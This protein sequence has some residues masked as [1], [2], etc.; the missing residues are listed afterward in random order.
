MV[1]I[2]IL[3]RKMNILIEEFERKI[4]N[5][6]RNEEELT[7]TYPFGQ[8]LGRDA[9]NRELFIILTRNKYKKE[10]KFSK[11]I[12]DDNYKYYYNFMDSS[13][14]VD[15][16][17]IQELLKI[18]GSILGY[19]NQSI[20]NSS[21]FDSLA[22]AND[23]SQN[24]DSYKYMNYGIRANH[25]M[26]ELYLSKLNENNGLTNFK[27]LLKDEFIYDYTLENTYDVL[28]LNPKLIL[29]IPKENL[30]F[31]HYVYALN[32]IFK[33]NVQITNEELLKVEKAMKV[34]Q[35]EMSERRYK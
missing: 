34:I 24:I 10:E 32:E 8:L 4:D 33:R 2:S 22:I 29:T 25:K 27:E 21:Y 13:L 35:Y 26:I 23:K 11:I 15:H 14:K 30:T 16:D 7:Q 31:D 18:D 5:L 17:Y 19:M 6:N 9:K 20:R 3:I 12:K 1:D 28:D